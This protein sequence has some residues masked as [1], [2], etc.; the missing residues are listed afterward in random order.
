MVFEFYSNR[1]KIRDITICIAWH[2]SGRTLE[3][4]AKEYKITPQRVR[5]IHW[6]VLRIVL[7]YIG[8]KGYDFSDKKDHCPEV[9]ECL[10]KYKNYLK[11]N[12]YR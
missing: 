6:R 7:G 9:V 5:Q 1:N 10:I 12:G 2:N 3:S 8:I 4:V 11:E